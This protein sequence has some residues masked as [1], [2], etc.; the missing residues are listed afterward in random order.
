MVQISASSGILTLTAT[1][2]SRRLSCQLP[3]EGDINACVHC[4]MLSQVV[5]PEGRGKAGSVDITQ[6]NERLS[7]LAD[8]LLSHLRLIPPADFPTSPARKQ[9]EPWN[10]VAMLQS[11]LLKDALSF[12]LPAASTDESRAHL[13]TVLLKDSEAVTTDGHRLHLAPL[14]APIPQPLLLRAPAAATMARMLAHGDQAILAQAGEV[15]RIKVGNWQLDTRLS[16]RTFPPHNQVI[17]NSDIQPTHIRLQA[18]LLSRALSRISR[19]TKDKRLRFRVNGAITLTTWESESGA[20]EMEV[21]VTSSTHEGDDLHIGFD[22]PYLNQAIPKDAQE[23]SLGFGGPLEPLRLDLD[24]GK[25]AVVMPLRL[26]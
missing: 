14:P 2:L 26:G 20:A 3:A 25:L 11:A 4:K 24:D 23:L 6:N 16:D 5:K 22:S 18:A 17:P 8:G 1:D 21:R 7:V 13:C 15:L 19:L 9:D 12:V 10:L